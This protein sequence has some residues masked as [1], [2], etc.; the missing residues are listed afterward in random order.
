[1]GIPTISKIATTVC[2]FFISFASFAQSFEPFQPRFNED[3]RGD[4]VLIGNNILGPSNNAFNDDNAYN[5]NEDMEYI[6]IDGDNSTFSSS[7]ADLV[8]PNPDCY[9]IRYAGLYWGA[10]NPGN[11][12]ITDV[13]IKGPTGGYVD[14]TGTIIHE[15]GTNSVD[16]GNSFSY[17][18]YADVTSIVQGLASNLGTYTIAN[19]SSDEG[20]TSDFGNG[21]GHSAGWSLFVVYEDPTLPGKSI[22]S[23][24]GFSSIN[25]PNNSSLDIPV[26]GFRTVPAPAP[27]R[28][29]F[30]FAALEGDKRI[31]GDR[32]GINF[33]ALSAPDRP[34]NN[35][36]NSTISQLSGLPV[37]NRVP[38]S[39]NTLGFDTGILEVPNPSNNVINND[40][41]SAVINLRTTGDT[42]F[43]YFFAFAVEIIEPDIILTKLVEDDAGN[44]IG[45]EV[46]GLGQSLNYV[47]GF[48]NVGNDNATNF[49]IK[50]I[51]PINIV[52]NYPGDLVLPP[53]VTVASYDPIT[54]ELILDV[55][56]Y[57]VEQNDPVYEIRIEVETVSTCA[58]LEDACSNIINNQA[59][60]TYNGYD[61]PTFQITDDPSL[62]SNTGCLLVPQATN[63]LADLDDC[64]FTQNEIL[65]GSSLEMTAAG[66]YDSYSWSTSPTGT[67]VIGTSQSITVTETGTYYVFNTAIAPCQ[68]IQQEF[69]VELY[70]GDVENPVI[71]YADE[72]VTCPNDGKLLPNIYL[73]GANDSREIQTNIPDSTTLTWE[74]LDETSCP[75]VLNTDCANEN[76]GCVW[77]EVFTGPNYIAD[78]SGQYRLTINY[79][80]G[81]FV[82]FYFNVYQNLLDPTVEASDI[83][84]TSPGS[85]TVNNVPTGYEYS[86]DGTTYQ[87]SNVF[88]VTTPGIYTVY[89]RQ[90]NIAT[91]P[92]VFTVPNIQIRER[93]F[94]VSTTVIQP[95]CH[96][97]KGS[98]QLAANDV[99]PQYSYELYQNGTLV[100]S[101]G[102]ILEN[103]YLFANLNPGTYTATVTT[104]DGCTYSEEL[105]IIQPELL[106]VT[107]ALTTPLT[108]TD[109]EITIYPV[110]GTPPYTYFINSTTEFQ[111]VPEV[112]VINSGVFDITVV[113]YNNCSVSTTVTVDDLPEPEYTV[114]HTDLLCYNANT[115]VIEFNV[116]NANGYT[117]EYSIDNGATYS[118]NSTFSNLGAGDY[119]VLIKYSLSGSECFTAVQTITISQPDE[120]LTATAGV[121]ELAGCGPS[122][123]GT[124]RITN[125]QGGTP[126]PAPNYYEYSFD[127]QATWTTINE[128]YVNPGTY[129]VYVRDANGCIYAMP[130]VVLDQEPPA[131]TITLSETE[132]NC[133]GSGNATVTITN[134]GGDSYSYDYY[135]DGV[136]NPNTENPEVFTNVPSGSHTISVEYTLLNVPTFSNL[137]YETFGYGEDTTSPGI[138]PVYYCFERQVVAT[139]CNG[140]PAI[141]DGDYSVTSNIEYPFGAW[142]N[143]T[144]YTPATT[145]PTPDGRFLVVNIGATIPAS[146]V[147]YEKDIIDIIPNQ[148]IQVE[149]A[150]INLL[151][152]G[153]NQY[154]PN[155]RVALVDASGTEISFYNTGDIPKTE[156]W[157]EYPTTPI[158]LDPG[159]NTSLK[160][161]LRS[162]VQ[163]TS[164]NDVAI[165]DLKVYQLPVACSTLVEFPFVVPSGNAFTADVTGTTM[166]S[167][168]G[169]SD[170]SITIAAENFDTANGYQYSIDNGVTWVTQTTSPH[171]IT[172]LTDGN[173]D[174]QIRYDDS[175]DTCSFS[176]TETIT[177]PDALTISLDQTDATCIDG[178]TITAT[179]T[180]GTPSYSYQLIDTVSPFTATDFEGNG[181]ITNV[182]AG[183]YTVEVTD[184]NGCTESTTITIDE[185]LLP[186]GTIDVNSDLCYDSV[187]AATIEVTASSGQPPYQFSNNGGAFQSSN[188]FENL[189]PGTYTIV[190]RDSYGCE[191]TLPAQTIEPELILSAVITKDLDCTTSPDAVITGTFSGGTAPY[192]YQ[193]SVDGGAYID[194]G[195][196]G[197]PFTYTTDTPGT[198]QFEVIDALGCSVASQ[199]NTI[200]AIT[201]PTATASATD[202]LCFDESNGQ[203]QLTAAGGSGGYTFSFNGSPF[204]ATSLY[205]GLNA[206]TTTATT[207]EYTYQIQD[208]NSCLSPVYTITLNNP[209]ELV[210]SATLSDNTTCS[211]TSEI[212]VTASGG[213]GNHAYSFNGNTSYTSTNVFTVNN[214][215]TTQTITYS[216]RD[217]NGCIITQTIDVPPFDPLT[218]MTFSNSNGI[219]CNDTTTDVTVTP[220]NGVGPFTFEITAPATATSNTTGATAGVFTGLIPG[221]YT[222]VIY[223][224]NG[225]EIT[226]S[227]VVA[228]ATTIAAS[229]S[230]TDQTC[231]GSDD[232]TATFTMTDVSAVGNYTYT[233]TPSAGTVTQTGNDIV[234]SGLPAGTYTLDV[235]DIN[236]GCTASATVTINAVTQIDFTVDASNVSCNNTLSTISFPTLSGGAGG[237]TYAYVASG[238]PA[239]TPG[240][241]GTTT[242]VDTAVLGLNIDVY[243]MDS[244]NCMVMNPV[245]IISDDLPTVSASVDNQCTASG[246]NFI[247]N[248]TATGVA[249]LLYSIDGVNFQAANTF[250]VTSGTYTVTVKDGNG[251]LV[252][253]TVTVNP[254]LTL[255]ANLDKE[256]TCSVPTDAQIT[257]TAAGG[258]SST[259]TYEVSTD[260]GATYSPM[261]SNVFNTSTAGTYTFSVTDAEGCSSTISF[262]LDPIPTTTFT[263]SQT[264]VSCN[265]GNDG[266]ITVTTTS[267]T[268]PFTYQLDSGTP[269]ASNVFTGLTQG[270]Y[271]VT[272]IDTKGCSYPSAPITINEP[273]VLT[274][275]DSVSTNTTC[276]VATVVTVL[277]Q[278]G[279][280]TLSGDYFYSFNGSSFSTDNTFTVNNNGTVQTVNYIVKD[281]NGCQVTGS[282]TIDPLDS[283]TALSFASTTVTCN[284]TTSDVTLTTTGGVGPLAYEI[285]APASATTNTTGATSGIFTGLNPGTYTFTVT[286]ANGCQFSDSYTVAP[287]VNIA[288][289]QSNTDQTCF[290]TDNGTATFTITDVSAVG[291]YTYTLTPSAGT[292]TQTGN[293]VTVNNLPA[294]SYT[295]NVED[296]A[297]GCTTSSTVLIEAATLIN[298]TANATNVSCNNAISTISFP[299]LSGG[300]GGYT[301]A[302]VSNGS[303]A[304]TAGDYG[305]STTVDT[306]VLGL[307][308]DVYVMDSNN[309]VVM[310]TVTITSDPVP[311]VSAS[312]TNQ[313]TANGSNFTIDA[314]ATGVATLTYSIDGTNFQ[315]GNT[316]TVVAGTYTV[317]VK[318]G[319]GCEVTDTVTV[320]PQ[321]T[322]AANLDKDITCSLPADA[323]VTLTATGGDATTYTYAYSS[324]GGATFTTIASNVFNTA[325]PGNYIFMVT[326]A[327]GCSTQ[328]TAPIEIT[329]AVNPD[330]T[331][332][333]TGFINC[334]GEE[335]ASISITPD[336]T[337]GQAP[338]SYEVFNTTT[339]TSYG[340]QTSGLPAGD[341]TVTVTDARGC[342]EVENI[343]ISQPDPIS[344]AHSAVPITC[345]A[346][347]TTQGSVIV[348]GVTGGVGPYNYFVTGTNGYDEV[349][350]NNTGTT[351][352]TFDVVDFGLYQINVVDAN[353][354]SVLI[355]DV[356]VASPPDDLDIT[357]NSTAN[358]STGGEAT[359]TVNTTLIGSGPFYFDIYDGTIPAAPPGGT[360]QLET[361]PGSITFTGLETGVLYTFIVYDSYTNCYYFE[362]AT[363]PIP[364]NST[365]TATAVSSNNIT[366]TGSADGNVSFT[367]NN[368]EATAIDVSFEIYDSLSLDPTGVMGTSTVPA[369]GSVTVTDLG[370]LDFG[371][372]FV[373]ITENSGANAGC[374]IVTP[375]FNITE[376][377]IDFNLTAS[378]T[379]NENCNDLGVISA[380][381]SDGTAPYQYQILLESDPAPVASSSGWA[382]PNTF[383]VPADAYTVYAMDAYGCI[384]DVDVTLIQDAEPVI[385]PQTAPCYEG[386]PIPVTITGSVSIGSPL[387]SINGTTFVSNPNF[388][389]STPGTY[390]LYI[391]DGNGCVAST[392]FVVNSQL[393]LS[394][395][396]TS[397]LDCTATPD[398]EITLTATGGDI[399]SYTYEVSTDGGTTYTTMATNVYTANTAGSYM[400]SVTDAQGCA[401]TTTYV[402][403]PI[404]STTFTTSQTEVSCNGGND[405]SI[406]VTTTSATGPFTYQLDAGT[407]QTSNVFTG[408]TQGT[409]TVTV[410]DAYQCTVTSAP[411]TI[412]EPL[413]LTATDSVSANSTCDVATVITVLGQDGTP[414]ASGGYYYNFNGTGFSTTNTFTVNNNG[415]VQTVNYTVKDAN[416]CEVTGSLMIDPLD[417]PTD[418]DFT[419]T[420]VTC[421]DTTSDV[422]LTTTGGVGP[423]SYEILA[424]ASATTNTTGATNG[425]F[426]GLVPGTYTFAVTDDNGCQ[427]TGTHTIAPAINI[428]VAQ[429][430]TDQICFGSDDGT[431]TFTMTD[432]SAV[433]NYTYTLTPAAGTVTQTGNEV[434][435]TGLPVGTYT[436][437]VQDNTTGCSASTTVTIDAATPINFT[438]N[439][440]NV[441]CNNAISTISFPTLSGGAGGY[442]YAYVT[443]GSP[444][445]TAGDFSTA[446]T[447]DTAVLGLVIDVYVMDSNNCIVMDTLTIVNDPLPTVT[448]SIDNQCTASG[449][450]FTISATSTGVATVLYSID[451]TNFQ[452]SNTFSVVAGT[453]T[454]TVRDGN[455]CTATDTVT[456]N[457][458]LTLAATLDKEITC[459]VPT[460]AQ[461]TLTASGGDSATYTYE[462]S[463]DGGATYTPMASNVYTTA[464]AG[465]YT[466]NVTDAQGCSTTATYVLD[467]I[468]TTTFTTSQTDV[469]C[470]GGSDGSI[471]ITTTS[472]TGPFMYQL[473][474][475]TP[476]TSNV[477]TGLSQGTYTVTVIDTRGC[478]YPSAPI[479]INEPVV[480]TA[481]DSMSINTTC[482]VATVITVLGQDGT[483]T[484]TGGYYYNFNGTGYTTTN[485]YTVNNNGTVQTVNY[486]VKDANGCVVSGSVTIDPL[487]PPTDLEFT[488]TPITC[489][490]STSDVTLTATGGVGPLQFEILSPASATSNTSGATSGV[491]TGLPADDYTFLVT[492]A[493]GCSYQELYVLEDVENILVTGQ[494]VSDVTCNP[495]ANGE[496]LFTV[497]NFT[498]TYS[499]S[500]NGAPAVTGQTNPTVSVTGLTAASTQT[501]VITD[502]T[503]GCTA[504]AS[505]DISQPAPLD[506]ILDTTVNANCNANAQVSVTASGGTGSYTYS[507][508]VSGSPAGTYSS[509]NTAVLDPAVSTAWDVYV[510]DA[511]GCVITTP[512]AITIDTDPIPTGLTVTGSPCISAANDYS[513]TVD[514]ATGIAPYTYSIG[515]GFQSSPTF[516]VTASG[517]YNITVKD[518]NGCTNTITYTID[519]PIGLTLDYAA[520]SCSDDDGEI[521]VLGFGGT[522]S[523]S[524]SIN[525]SPASVTL[526]GNVFSGVPSGTYNVTITDTASGCTNDVSITLDPA[527]PV[528]FTL[529]A[530]D[531][532]CN[533]G[534]DGIITVTLPASNDNPVYTYEITAPITVAPQTSNIFTG[535]A[536]GTYTVQVTSGKNCITT[537]TITV[538]EPDTII[539]SDP[540]VSQYACASGNTMNYATITV[541]TV[542][543]GSGVYPIYEFIENGVVVQSGSSNTY[544]EADSTGGTFTINVYDDAGC[545]GSAATAITINP[546]ISLDSL[547]VNVTNE[548]TCTNLESI[549]VTANTTGGTPTNLEYTVEDVVGTTTGGVYSE[550]NTTGD[551]TGLDIGNYIITVTNLDT[552]CSL[553]TV[554]YVNNPNTFDLVVDSVIDV[555][556]YNGNDG[557]VNITFV[558]LMISGTNPDQAGPFTYTISDEAG[559]AVI[560]DTAANAGPITITGLMGGTYTIT[561]TLDSNPFCTV[562]KNFTITRPTAEL[563]VIAT[564]ASS[565]TCDNNLGSIEA[566]ATGGWS[567]TY[568]Y[569]LMLGGAVVEAYSPNS[570]FS[571]LAAGTYT[572]NVRDTSGCIASADV[573]LE[574]PAP[575]NATFTPSTTMLLCFG[576]QD[577]SITIENV[578]GGQGS[579]YTYV[580][581]T[582]APTPSSSGPQTT[583]V[584]NDLAAGTYSITITDGYNCEFTSADIVIDQPAQIEASLVTTTTQSCAVESTLTL[585]ATGGVAPYTYSNTS[586]FNTTLGTFNNTITFPVPHGTYEYYVR[587]ANG[588]EIY[589]SNE[590]TIDPLE[591]LVVSL[592][593]STTTINC[594]GDNNGSIVATAQGGLGNYVYTLEDTD[595]NTIN[596]TQDSPGVFTDLFAGDYI[597]HV[598]S[599]DCIANSS[600][601]SITEPSEPL[602]ASF[603]VTDITCTGS[604]NGI[605]E[606]TASGG[607][608]II[609]YAI[610]PQ[611]NQFFETNV[612]ENLAPGDYTVIVQDVLGCFITFD[613]TITDPIPVT[614][615]ITPNSILAE[616]CTGEGDGEFS[617]D[618]AGG[619]LPY[620]VS[621]DDYDGT[622]ST[623]EL[624]QT[625]FEFTGLNGGDHIV[626]VRDA[627]GCE[628]EWY[629]PFPEA[630]TLNPTVEVEFNCVSNSLTN[631]VTVYVDDSITDTSLLEYS[632]DGGPYQASNVFTNV[633]AGTNH[634][635]DVKHDNGCIQN[636]DFFVVQN[637]QPLSLILNEGSEPGEIVATATGGTGDY[638]FSINNGTY[639]SNNSFMVTQTGAYYVTVIDS[640][641]CQAD[642]AIEINIVGPCMSNYFTPNNDGI[643]DTWAPGCTEDFPNLTF[644]IFDRYGRKVATLQV[645]EYWDGTYNGTELPTGD[646]W[647]V[648]KTNSQLLD[649]EYVGHF[650]L[651]R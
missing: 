335:T 99:E 89:V 593:A 242:T 366:C 180:G 238:S 5:S 201:L 116:T 397:G 595:G 612:F 387:Y 333:Q 356:L 379:S 514:V 371:N 442:T 500:I 237:Y 182:P 171:T 610:S 649:K 394:A 388:T 470:N 268:G 639:G 505:I 484:T 567:T 63:F 399:T 293:T 390:T 92:C 427:F 143:P 309:C 255:S 292:A 471:T 596:A 31:S 197:S 88:T 75:V 573:T 277:G 47:I 168:A 460:E 314:T 25:T 102:P 2:L 319:N 21:T 187:D 284:D 542:T 270:T 285:I 190:V 594:A 269:Q 548:I 36:F 131:P 62:N 191:V 443:A 262:V 24:D 463:S 283:P 432:V 609:K 417:G 147:L 153:N 515:N 37:N 55:A 528:S 363:D 177:T 128:A 249:T 377:A 246:G 227:H 509:S 207:T 552:G 61:N 404:P 638:E 210:A 469:S 643:A 588:C 414:T 307:V 549:S 641:G 69:I 125:P 192:S 282:L 441:N 360:W 357:I 451:G 386:N 435:V 64:N 35:F 615:D 365:L 169:A 181:V 446:T 146:E 223:D 239:P 300:A 465:T 462:V 247:I 519:D 154:D 59:F 334:N 51:L 30:A 164:G 375:S 495:G 342:T 591:E 56:D 195:I 623:G 473:D 12:S 433:G 68:S 497:T 570:F 81:C 77:N 487:D 629:I 453:Y 346:T 148:P 276:D 303:P 275:T 325:T 348:D 624:T 101:V 350:L 52:F 250:S 49:Q 46:V 368:P 517:T 326:D 408:L 286:D 431:A 198:Y 651:Y 82:Q 132:F 535:L 33:W 22:T 299:T 367:I 248:A 133:D 445:P 581:N 174:I 129:T 569:E 385:D 545:V 418:L 628:S 280:P 27:V 635:I 115:G 352:T 228:P 306:G 17:A 338:Y 167:C 474:A 604:N 601:V 531:A 199:V 144:D 611:L 23:F 41:T 381:G 216:V 476:Q 631:T 105:T 130:N 194:L 95:L 389:I 493:N 633:P 468:P 419:S 26:T 583:N 430:N 224:T 599:E 600:P 256:I 240:D 541:S 602:T 393:L 605:L 186:T 209:T 85:I 42:Y 251:C 526:T 225:C 534:S 406:T 121:S 454:I 494:L 140:N 485:T 302:Y 647:Y 28:A 425:I 166:V 496:V 551:F 426:T 179:S 39:T 86:L 152:T 362:S 324:D 120:A 20:E 477:F 584:F 341:Y 626:Y 472:A 480:L 94:T 370:P 15:A 458:Q 516:T 337:L 172:G 291:N 373:L 328:T 134:N 243:V 74:L 203:I 119:E 230:S 564:E 40:A 608:G 38:N 511:N 492:D 345:S 524:F 502:E 43:P 644:D 54:R 347:G 245:T 576:D 281:D 159:A 574:V 226:A 506:L 606:I 271:T 289:A 456:V 444:A 592:G 518:A 422:T 18:C 118:S 632:L 279:T 202:P 76:A 32:L 150:A 391:Q 66:G 114:T 60:A 215:T 568:E 561:A 530:N 527:T 321:L 630:V 559:T 553:E 71:P 412:T 73:C 110:G 355:Q 579:N 173:Y 241:F 301:Y 315:T 544:T 613:F 376:S 304:P 646:Y 83:I 589:V 183:S 620:S 9:A 416:G 87:T 155:L 523:Y 424:P 538:S 34:S 100:N 510:Q 138:N 617:V 157:I 457:Q 436:F 622:Y 254:Q 616:L 398:A 423:L 264:D 265:G 428:A 126:F 434:L 327:N 560:T 546:Y 204:T 205:D 590:I 562:V 296:T 278:D 14:V 200:D 501:I 577:A 211:A 313:C 358:C 533:G 13:K 141:N 156:N 490:V 625:V 642:A 513:F 80:G 563:S 259:Y 261:A 395:N 273:L 3:L 103:T 272:V 235:E 16:G 340:T 329:P 266:S 137:L 536:A 127:N 220:T 448:A 452:S 354:C 421:N 124:I 257:L 323:Q 547:D 218:G 554:H 438:A 193:V 571:N 78:T 212:T 208:S 317:T 231:F 53:G 392:P 603:N 163:Q 361:S 298:F 170:G 508:V 409:Y 532:T 184:A 6:D 320:S 353:G 185:P 322:L 188:I 244:N 529:E 640:A 162:N 98:I 260:G 582:I 312:V 410:I 585:T 522:G 221:D 310:D 450:N 491:F 70:G 374:N 7:S 79:P 151:K 499:Y 627:E 483:P 122:G 311:T 93:D 336:T 117:L 621:L 558:D 618:I 11:E 400:F 263:T 318:D 466:F 8:I 145:P 498:G 512:L 253:D 96:D 267:A 407:P 295:F 449:N 586:T 437:S 217:D 287:A 45:G 58:E 196:T 475:G 349:E 104:E 236:T 123:E 447:V 645:G 316:F 557:S 503:T 411:I 521:T 504:T 481:T 634:Y 229:G 464:T 48:Q 459:S 178:A 382:T 566:V 176:F 420:I 158:T 160:F 384:R 222:F 648:V 142:V 396:L 136:L 636:T 520:P 232:G 507:F 383:T 288:V 339:S 50:D 90:M 29:N 555:T 330:I 413:P 343:T 10:V 290:G 57:L 72:V 461:I 67:P 135:I 344:V 650:T 219:T 619:S 455:G 540:I 175:T 572:V 415:T 403:D 580:L 258:D 489:L 405:G 234:V 637:Y 19:V 429:T 587:D 161:I 108:C 332:A 109:G 1:M 149:F 213:T 359:I 308:I 543:G 482:D 106:T 189:V 537:E 607:T 294:G 4:I 565:V 44:D 206:N 369:G 401:T 486:S 112:V 597:V 351:S 525:P 380:V 91:N 439:A 479:T 378:V 65:C 84:C 488:S 467:P 252:S 305:T 578:T 274:A 556:C 165:D 107:A 364:T 233:L 97:D 331:V 614:L 440:T 111:T 539:V 139:Q 214:T 478:S 598:V 113:D 372:Y 575:I 550:T 402:L 297:T